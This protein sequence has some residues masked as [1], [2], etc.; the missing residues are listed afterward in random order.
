[1]VRFRTAAASSQRRSSDDDRRRAMNGRSYFEELER[2]MRIAD[3]DPA[4]I[5]EELPSLDLPPGPRTSRVGGSIATDLKRLTAEETEERRA[6]SE[7]FLHEPI[8]TFPAEDAA[9]TEAGP[10]PVGVDAQE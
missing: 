10:Q 3:L 9:D 2:Q 4:T 1:M 6:R 8:K 5:Q 7:A